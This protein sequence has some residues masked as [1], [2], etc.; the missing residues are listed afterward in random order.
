MVIVV[1]GGRLLVDVV[2]REL[3][4]QLLRTSAEES[5]AGPPCLP[6]RHI[7]NRTTQ[8]HIP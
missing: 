4:V 8:H 5:I 2:R 6:P 3:Q 1:V 7:T